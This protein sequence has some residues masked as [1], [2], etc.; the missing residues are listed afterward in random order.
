MKTSP[1]KRDYAKKYYSENK[2]HYSEYYKSYYQKN[3]DKI[4]EKQKKYNKQN[5]KKINYPFVAFLF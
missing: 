5:R 3:K 4:L 2:K 1:G